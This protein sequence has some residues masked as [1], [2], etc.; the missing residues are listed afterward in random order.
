MTIHENYITGD[1]IYRSIDKKMKMNHK[2]TFMINFDEIEES[3][4]I[5]YHTNKYPNICQGKIL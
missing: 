1:Q 3:S 4:D 2:I 5:S